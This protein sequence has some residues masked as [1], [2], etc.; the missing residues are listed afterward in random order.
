MRS[1]SSGTGIR[2]AREQSKSKSVGAGFHAEAA[3]ADRGGLPAA[4]PR[5]GAPVHRLD[6]E[7][8]GDTRAMPAAETP[9]AAERRAPGYTVARPPA[10][11]PSTLPECESG[12]AYQS[13]AAPRGARH[14][15]M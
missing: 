11:A 6:A 14:R 8:P 5:T 9:A 10:G 1:P 2:V 3:S 13:E 4:A 15:E 7:R 12:C